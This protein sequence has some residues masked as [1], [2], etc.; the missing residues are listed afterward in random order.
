MCSSVTRRRRVGVLL[1]VRS[2]EVAY[3][4]I[5]VV[6]LVVENMFKLQKLKGKLKYSALKIK[7]VQQILTYILYDIFL[8]RRY[9]ECFRIL[10]RWFATRF[11]YWKLL[12]IHRKITGKTLIHDQQSFHVE[13]CLFPTF[14]IEETASFLKFKYSRLK[15]SCLISKVLHSWFISCRTLSF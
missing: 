2:L 4:C 14:S 15:G 8:S 7:V 3:Y 12:F 13:N 9:F 6:V 10:Y 5:R 1:W 11:P